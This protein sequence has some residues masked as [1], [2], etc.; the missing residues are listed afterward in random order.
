M[1][2]IRHGSVQAFNS[3]LPENASERHTQEEREGGR[4]SILFVIIRLERGREGGREGGRDTEKGRGEGEEKE[5]VGIH[6]E[7]KVW[8]YNA[9]QDFVHKH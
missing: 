7:F 4:M 8:K 2:Y 9:I 3:R 5:R 6:L 1:I